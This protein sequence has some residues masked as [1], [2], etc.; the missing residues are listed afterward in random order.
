LPR[1]VDFPPEALAGAGIKTASDAVAVA[2]ADTVSDGYRQAEEGSQDPET[3]PAG[4]PG[5]Y[6][7]PAARAGERAAPRPSPSACDRI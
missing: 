1:R 2:Q 6:G 4:W 5:A 3:P 7:R